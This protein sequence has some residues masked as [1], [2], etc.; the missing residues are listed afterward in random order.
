MNKFFINEILI[1]EFEL[2]YDEFYLDKYQILKSVGYKK[3]D[4][5]DLIQQV[6]DEV[7]ID[8]SKKVNIKGGFKIFPSN[9][10]SIGKEHIII[11]GITF[12]CGEIIK[13]CL[14]DSESVVLLIC[15]I[16]NQVEKWTKSLLEKNEPLAGYFSDLIASELVEMAADKLELK[17][18]QMLKLYKIKTTTR[19]SPG[20][21]GWDVG[22]QQKLFSI[23]PKGF[24][25]V[26]LNNESMMF[27]VKSISAIIGIGSNVSKKKY[28]CSKCVLES[29]L[30]KDRYEKYF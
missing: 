22:E 14:T 7:L 28:N 1:E 10:I 4:I 3:D 16:G 25:G 12:N 5:P 26:T 6:F 29:C 21:C 15:T 27:P 2:D 8:L 30:K 13:S 23:L 17:L 18:E 11:S 24:C 20:Y 9:Q 19:F